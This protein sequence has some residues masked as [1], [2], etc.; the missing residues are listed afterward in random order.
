MISQLI[1]LQKMNQ[2]FD[3]WS[4]KNAN[5]DGF[6]FSKVRTVW[7]TTWKQFEDVNFSGKFWGAFSQLFER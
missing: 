7:Q 5:I 6:I 4:I 2:H 1:N 3:N